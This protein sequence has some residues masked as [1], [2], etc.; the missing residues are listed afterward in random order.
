MNINSNR[1]RL[2]PPKFEPGGGKRVVLDDMEH[3]IKDLLAKQASG[4]DMRHILKF[5]H[6]DPDDTEFNDIV[7]SS[8]FKDLTEIELLIDQEEKLA[9]KISKAKALKKAIEDRPDPDPEPDP[10]PEPEP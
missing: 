1:N 2:D 3:S 9:E 4:V 6:Y 10:E 7:I 5:S 8:G